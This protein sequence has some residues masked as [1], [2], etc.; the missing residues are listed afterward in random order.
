MYYTHYPVQLTDNLPDIHPVAQ[1]SGQVWNLCR[2]DDDIF[3]LHDRGVFLVEGNSMK[4]IAD[5]AGAWGCQPVV[6]KK[7]LIY[8]GVYDGLYLMEK[9]DGRLFVK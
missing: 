7:R 1:S 4:K 8:V 6:G 2:I 5:V 9:K 3:C